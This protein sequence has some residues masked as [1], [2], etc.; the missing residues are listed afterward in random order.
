MAPSTKI[1]P[2][3]SPTH[4]PGD[5]NGRRSPELISIRTSVSVFMDALSKARMVRKIQRW[6]AYAVARSASARKKIPDKI[7]PNGSARRRAPDLSRASPGASHILC[8]R[9]RSQAL[10]WS[11]KLMFRGASMTT[12]CPEQH[13]FWCTQGTRWFHQALSWTRTAQRR[14]RPGCL[15]TALWSPP[16]WTFINRIW[17]D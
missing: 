11:L 9:T 5:P 15:G 13:I 17:V 7:P 4:T 10:A 16:G 12:R 3:F 14:T 8:S 1:H 2:Y 6:L